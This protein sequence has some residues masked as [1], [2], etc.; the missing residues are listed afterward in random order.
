M[1]G[2]KMAVT[3]RRFLGAMAL[4]GV[5][6]TVGMPVAAAAEPEVLGVGDPRYL[7]LTMRGYNRRFTARPSKI[8]LPGDAEQVRLAVERSLGE[9]LTLGVRSGGHCFDDFVDNDRTRSLIDLSK[10]TGIGWDAGH[11]AFSVGPGAELS[12]V[13]QALHPWNVTLPA[14]ICLAV[15]IGG[16]VCGGG[17]GPLSRSRGLVADHLYGVEVVTA[18]A[19]G[20]ASLVLATRD[21]PHSDLWWAHTGGGGGNFGIVTRYLFRSP[22]ADGGDPARALPRSPGGML[23]GRLLLPVTTEESFVRFLG[24]YLAFHEQHGA[25]GDP[26]AG[27]YAPLNF[28]TDVVASAEVLIFF[29]AD[30]PDARARVDEFV[31]AITAGV[32]PGAVVQPIERSSYADT[33]SKVYYPKGAVYPRV[34]VKA[35]YLRKAYDTEQLRALYRHVTNPGV[36]GES[37]L[38]FLPFGGA[39]NAVAPEATAFPARDTMMKMLIH[40]A[41]RLPGDDER[42]LGWAREMYR[43]VYAGSGG[44]PVPGAAHGGSYINYPDPDLADPRWNSSGVPWHALYYGGNYAR[45]LEVK[46]RYDPAGAFQHALSIGRPDWS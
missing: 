43:D 41:W 2:E 20:T 25:P 32:T 11:G 35:A 8:F 46:Q 29:D 34:K 28:R 1:T 3:R 22:D 44:V 23:H 30:A 26:F 39:I 4:G 17:Y 37:Q 42:F 10:L 18:N 36:V 40:A 12:A 5:A 38:E 16:H 9:G 33:V 19:D 14:G 31:A 27:L 15:G 45:L 13:Y 7:P 24:N 6:T 21:G